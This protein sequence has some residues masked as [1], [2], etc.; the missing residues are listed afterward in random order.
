MVR[1]SFRT[2]P[3]VG[4]RGGVGLQAAFMGYVWGGQGGTG[5]LVHPR[6]GAAGGDRTPGVGDQAPLLPPKKKRAGGR[7]AGKNLRFLRS[8]RE[9]SSITCVSVTG[10]NRAGFCEFT[11]ENCKGSL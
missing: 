2:M 5:I 7:H 9:L 10:K 8:T 3:G 11:D 4:Q 6:R 1:C